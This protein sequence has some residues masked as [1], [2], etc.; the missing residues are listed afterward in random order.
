[1]ESLRSHLTNYEQDKEALRLTKLRLSKAEKMLK[2]FEWEAEVMQQRFDK[3]K[4]ERDELYEKF[5]ASI[6]DVQQKTGAT[7]VCATAAARC[8]VPLIYSTVLR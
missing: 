5:E 1:M 4:S 8:G 2:N 3:V 7:G 6:Y